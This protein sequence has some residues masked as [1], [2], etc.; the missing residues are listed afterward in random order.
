[1]VATEKTKDGLAPYARVCQA[2][3]DDE[4]L[5][6]EK[7]LVVVPIGSPLDDTVTNGVLDNNSVGDEVPSSSSISWWSEVRAQLIMS[8]PVMLTFLTRKSVDVVSV[9]FV[10]HLGAEYLS[11]AGIASVTANVSGHSMVIGLAGAL[12]TICSQAYG[13]KDFVTFSLA[14]QRAMLILALI[15]CFPVS[16][17]W[18]YR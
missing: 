2:N 11:A 6:N 3:E 12:S 16:V 15:V 1:M 17:L 9:V 7:D 14:P 4:G 10:G 8:G 13:S 18:I 5:D